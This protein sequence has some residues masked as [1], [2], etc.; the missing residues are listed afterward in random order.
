MRWI[1]R[2]VR[3]DFFNGADR[4]AASLLQPLRDHGEVRIVVPDRVLFGVLRG[5]RREQ[6]HGLAR[7]LLD[8]LSAESQRGKALAPAAARTIVRCGFGGMEARSP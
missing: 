3:I 4:P 2:N 7:R 1:D 8:G 5:L 6:D